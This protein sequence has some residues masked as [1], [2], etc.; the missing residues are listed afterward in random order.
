MINII[1]VSH[2]TCEIIII[3]IILKK[4]MK[5]ILLVTTLGL[6]A[7]LTNASNEKDE[8]KLADKDKQNS[9]FFKMSRNSNRVSVFEQLQSLIRVKTSKS[10]FAVGG[11]VQTSIGYSTYQ[12]IV[13]L[14]GE[15]NVKVKNTL[16]YT[17]NPS[18]GYKA[19]IEIDA[20]KTVVYIGV[21]DCN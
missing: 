7:L 17:L 21:K 6:S 8:M 19:I 16:V 4:S 11:N 9:T 1:D 14:L 20:N 12:D 3:L 2:P 10:N 5:K 13:E 18:N 15:P